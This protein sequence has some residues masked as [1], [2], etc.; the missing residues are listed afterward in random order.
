MNTLKKLWMLFALVI[1]AVVILISVSLIVPVGTAPAFMP[2]GQRNSTALSDKERE[3]QILEALKQETSLLIAGA[4]FIV[5]IFL[6][7]FF[8]SSRTPNGFPSALFAMGALLSAGFSIWMGFRVIN[9]LKRL[10]SFGISWQY[11]S[12]SRLFYFQ[13]LQKWSLLVLT[14]P[15]SMY[16]LCVIKQK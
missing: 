9:E 7:H 13:L 8:F 5:N 12:E 1:I 2:E 14:I 16:V 15:L 3:L 4:G 6:I 11:W 10:I